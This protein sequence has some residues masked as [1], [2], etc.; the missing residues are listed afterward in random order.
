L[1]FIGSWGRSSNRFTFWYCH[2]L[3]LLT[4]LLPFVA[5][6]HIHLV[7]AT[8]CQII[9]LSSFRS[10]LNFFRLDWLLLLIELVVI[11]K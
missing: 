10:L 2:L 1:D 4:L 9:C 7:G 11:F 5:G 3:A 6:L 8:R